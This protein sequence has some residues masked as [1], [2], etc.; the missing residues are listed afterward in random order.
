MLTLHRHPLGA[1]L[2]SQQNAWSQLWLLLEP[3]RSHGRV[4]QECP[5]EM[6]TELIKTNQQTHKTGPGTEHGWLF[7][8]DGSCLNFGFPFVLVFEFEGWGLG[9]PA[10]M[11]IASYPAK[12]KL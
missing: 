11:L 12:A 7:Q 1:V 2:R 9:K 6:W 3:S 10:N 4:S 8:Q 5:A